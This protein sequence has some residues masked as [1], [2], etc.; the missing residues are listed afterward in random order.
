MAPSLLPTPHCTSLLQ[1]YRLFWYDV[2]SIIINIVHVMSASVNLVCLSLCR[3]LPALST[4]PPPPCVSGPQTRH[5]LTTAHID[6]V[7]PINPTRL[8]QS[9]PYRSYTHTIATL[10]ST[11]SVP[12]QYPIL[13]FVLNRCYNFSNTYRDVTS[14]IACNK[15]HYVSQ[16]RCVWRMTCTNS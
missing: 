14:M 16:K 2:I 6:R 3:S 11:V 1:P 4:P 15:T 8:P 13:W 12:F 10:I 7:H 5:T 9:S